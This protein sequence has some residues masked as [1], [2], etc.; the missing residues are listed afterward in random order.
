MGQVCKLSTVISFNSKHALAQGHS[1][2]RGLLFDH[3]G[4]AQT[5]LAYAVKCSFVKY[6]C[7]RKHYPDM[8]MLLMTSHSI[9]ERDS[10]WPL[11]CDAL[12][13]LVAG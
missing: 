5:L 13:T 6:Q 3:S 10:R 7:L 12:H 8:H 2:N 9:Q 11:L 1:E 4:T